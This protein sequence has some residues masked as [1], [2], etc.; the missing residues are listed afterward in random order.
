MG[1]SGGFRSHLGDVN[2][3][4]ADGDC[5]EAVEREGREE[6]REEDLRQ[7]GEVACYA[8]ALRGQQRG[9]GGGGG[10]EHWE[11]QGRG[12]QNCRSVLD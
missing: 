1:G 11:G 10:R 2:G 12:V 5:E 8:E 3:E 9:G 4:A 6:S 7:H